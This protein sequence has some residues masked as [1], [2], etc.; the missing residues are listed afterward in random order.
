MLKSWIAIVVF[1]LIPLVSFS[2]MINC[3]PFSNTPLT[4]L[5]EKYHMGPIATSSNV[6][7]P[8]ES[9]Q[10]VKATTKSAGLF[11]MICIYGTKQSSSSAAR[12]ISVKLNKQPSGFNWK[13]N[14]NTPCPNASPAGCGIDESNISPDQP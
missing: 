10:F 4:S 5:Q 7:L 13:S 8:L 9:V 6:A 14:N 2:E 3:P 12:Y 11:T 1:I